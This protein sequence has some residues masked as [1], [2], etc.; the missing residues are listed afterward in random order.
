[1]EQQAGEL[2]GLL[3]ATAAR[4]LPAGPLRRKL[5]RESVL[6][7]RR[8]VAE[9]GCGG[10]VG[11]REKLLRPRGEFLYGEQGLFALY[12]DDLE[13]EHKNWVC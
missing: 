2:C 9:G 12:A 13:A 11:R 4:R 7:E 1:M 8:R 5:R 3:G 10:G 6:G